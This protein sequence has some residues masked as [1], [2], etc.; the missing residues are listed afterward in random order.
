MVS[1]IIYASILI[2]RNVHI[3]SEMFQIVYC[4]KDKIMVS[5]SEHDVIVFDPGKLAAEIRAGCL[6]KGWPL[7]KNPVSG[8][9][10][11]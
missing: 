5:E 7:R 1:I 8:Y 11:W 3:C 10:V 9:C 2:N 4:W 6:R